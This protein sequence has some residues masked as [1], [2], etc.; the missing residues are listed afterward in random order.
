MDGCILC[1]RT[2]LEV[3]PPTTKLRIS[4]SSDFTGFHLWFVSLLL[5]CPGVILS[6]IIEVGLKLF[7]FFRFCSSHKLYRH[8]ESKHLISP[9][10]RANRLLFSIGT[11]N[12]LSDIL[13][14]IL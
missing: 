13:A 2:G 12:T 4:L 10:P 1:N 3:Q 9:L 11:A 14:Y 5:V 7:F 6:V 8:M